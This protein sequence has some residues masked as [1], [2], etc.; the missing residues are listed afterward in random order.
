MCRKTELMEKSSLGIT[1]FVIKPKIKVQKVID[2]YKRVSDYLKENGIRKTEKKFKL[3]SETI[4]RYKRK[5]KEKKKKKES[6]IQPKVLLLDIET[7][8]MNVLVWGLYLQRISHKNIVNEWFIISW[9][10]KWLCDSKVISDVVTPKEALKRKD[11]RI[12]K[13]IWNLIN[14]ADIVVTHNGDSF[15][16]RKLNARFILN[17]FDP[18]LPYQSI[19]TLTQSRSKFAFSSHKQDYI[20]KLLKL[21]EKIHT[22]IEL[23]YN[24][25]AG[26]KESLDR[27]V[28][29]NMQDVNGLEEMYL[30]LRPWMKNHPNLLVYSTTQTEGCPNCASRKIQWG[31][32]YAT[33]AGRYKAYRCLDCGAIGR[34]KKN[35]SK[36]IGRSIGR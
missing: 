25:M 21:P 8:F 28:E 33:P 32:Y 1:L 36:S 5:H 30:I 16:M 18:P 9:S 20:T 14:E 34:D 31:G 35:Q 17:G 2:V 26:K 4:Y 15:D 3:S 12:L 22:E 13:G 19:D 24:C 29:Y 7:S 6:F 10:A 27:M 11:K 23:W